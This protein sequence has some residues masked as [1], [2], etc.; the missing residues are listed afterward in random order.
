MAELSL[1]NLSIIAFTTY[2]NSMTSRH[3]QNYHH[4]YRIATHSDT[5]VQVWLKADSMKVRLWSYV[6]SAWNPRSKEYIGDQSPVEPTDMVYLHQ[7]VIGTLCRDEQM[8]W[9]LK[10][11]LLQEYD[12]RRHRF[13]PTSRFYTNT[14]KQTPTLSLSLNLRGLQ[15]YHQCIQF[16]WFTKCLYDLP[17]CV[18]GNSHAWHERTSSGN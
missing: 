18:I 17:I 16:L 3:Y 5:W 2:K 9:L 13:P 10:T 4:T 8:M 12:T 15:L 1:S 14:S 7:G 11:K 6:K